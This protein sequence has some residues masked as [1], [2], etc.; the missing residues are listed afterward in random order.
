MLSSCCREKDNSMRQQFSLLSCGFPYLCGCLLKSKK[1]TFF[2]IFNVCIILKYRTTLC[3][4]CF[5][6]LCHCTLCTH[7]F[8]IYDQVALTLSPGSFKLLLAGK[9]VYVK[10]ACIINE[11]KYAN[12]IHLQENSHC[13]LLLLAAFLQTVAFVVA[14]WYLPLVSMVPQF[15]LS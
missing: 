3:L 8:L 15:W 1:G 7:F 4:S 12:R 11:M 5:I 13:I 14:C 9:Y 10:Q 2:A 6:L